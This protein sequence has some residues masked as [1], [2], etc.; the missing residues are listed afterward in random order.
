M[1]IGGGISSEMDDGI[2]DNW[3]WYTVSSEM[4]DG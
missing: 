2:N 1:I 3:W 4:D